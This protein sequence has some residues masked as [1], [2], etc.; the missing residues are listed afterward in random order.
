M[1]L[2]GSSKASPWPLENGGKSGA[3]GIENTHSANEM[4]Y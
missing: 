4:K 1:G 2:T 3:D